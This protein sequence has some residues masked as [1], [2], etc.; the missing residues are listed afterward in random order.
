MKLSVLIIFLIVSLI[1]FKAY[2]YEK[3]FV[4]TQ[5][6]TDDVIRVQKL[7]PT[8]EVTP[9]DILL[10]YSHESKSILGYARVEVLEGDP[11]FFTATVKTH[12]KSGLI[13]PENYLRKIDLTETNNEM[14][15]RFDLVYR[16]NRKASSKYKPLVYTGPAQGF[17]APNLIKKEF[18][19]GP[20]IFGYGITS[21]LQVNANLISAMFN[22]ANISLKN[23][24]FS[25][26]D[27]EIAIEN[28][29]QYF[30]KKTKGTY[31]FTGYFDSISNSNFN[32]Y[33]KVRVFTKKPADEFLY[34]S[35]E[36]ENELNVEIQYSYGYLFNSW[37]RLLFGPKVDINKKKVGGLI[38]YYIIDKEFHTMVGVSSNDFSQFKVGKNGYLLNLD[39]WW[40]F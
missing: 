24:I 2:S 3:E 32:S 8:I 18:L 6:L 40:R 34:N 14:P 12:N 35:G 13:R 7:D 28:G 16:E 30:H 1:S 21:K 31:Q 25:N 39:F 15:A 36:Y 38:G 20:S 33:L 19:I 9:G 27:Y 11:L 17:T 22:I 4:L 26:D 10:V 23:T 37:N 5:I 29:F